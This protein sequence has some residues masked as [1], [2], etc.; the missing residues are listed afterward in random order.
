MHS[1]SIIIR[2][3]NEEKWIGRCISRIK[4]QAVLIPVQVTVVDSGSTDKTLAKAALYNANIVTVDNY[5]PGLAINTGILHSTG[6]IIVVLSAHCIPADDQWLSSLIKPLLSCDS[7]TVATYGRQLPTPSSNAADTRDLLISFGSEDRLQTKDTFFHNANSAFLRTTWE[8]QPF[9]QE[10]TNIEDRL[11]AE[12]IIESGCTIQYCSSAAVY[13]WHGIHQYGNASRL[14][15]TISTLREKTKLLTSVAP[16][17]PS[18]HKW[19]GIV[20]SQ[21]PLNSYLTERIAHLSDI[22]AAADDPWELIVYAPYVH[23]LSKPELSV[24]ARFIPRSLGD[25]STLLESVLSCLN[26][27]EEY[28]GEVVDALGI[29]NIDYLYRTTDD[30]NAIAGFFVEYDCDIVV[31]EYF[32]GHP[33]DTLSTTQEKASPASIFSNMHRS[34][35]VSYGTLIPG[36]SLLASA[37]MIRRPNDVQDVRMC[38]YPITGQTKLLKA[39]TLEELQDLVNLINGRIS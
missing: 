30:I 10:V 37:S 33:C 17:Y 18:P 38:K 2:T 27:H 29:F 25:T 34:L 5:L 19:I 1:I 8:L 28:C 22:L 13:H 20:M 15:G 21:K 24:N 14:K 9:D 12:K 23:L 11:W 35:S 26:Q 31:S 32:E 16:Y 7:N 6:S 36:Y 39:S 4:S 3:L